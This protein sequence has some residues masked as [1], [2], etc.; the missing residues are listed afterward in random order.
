MID[1]LNIFMFRENSKAENAF[2][3]THRARNTY[4]AYLIGQCQNILFLNS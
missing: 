2:K 1:A 3:K 4:I